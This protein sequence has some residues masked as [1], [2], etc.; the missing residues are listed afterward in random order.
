MRHEIM[1]SNY[2]IFK[3]LPIKKHLTSR[4]TLYYQSNEVRSRI[5]RLGWSR[6]SKMQYP[7]KSN[8]N[9]SPQKTHAY[10]YI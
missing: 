7:L 10:F 9:I 8:K 5:L 1:L 6:D 3:V 4:V 2:F